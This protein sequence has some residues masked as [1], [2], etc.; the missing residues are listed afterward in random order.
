VYRKSFTHPNGSTT[1]FE[2]LLGY[3]FDTRIT[4]GL[5]KGQSDTVRIANIS[6][7]LE[8]LKRCV[9]DIAHP[10]IFPLIHSGHDLWLAE[11]EQRQTREWLR[12]VEEA[13]L[14]QRQIKGKGRYEITNISDLDAIHKDLVVCQTRTFG[15]RSKAHLDARAS[16]EAA[17]EAF[18]DTFQ[19]RNGGLE[20]SHV[21]GLQNRVK[22]RLEFHKNR[23][24]G[25]GTYADTTMH[26]LEIQRS[27]VSYK[28]FMV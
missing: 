14:T 8:L 10:L 28:T 2:I 17:S 4:T 20:N 23:W 7:S 6:S 1:G 25:T 5:C 15:I 27:A 11:S 24:L 26:R 19:Q 12:E 21:L 13:V 16:M 3:D 18:S 22:S 9:E